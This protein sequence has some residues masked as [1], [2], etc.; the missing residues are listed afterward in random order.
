M[1]RMSREARRRQ[2]LEKNRTDRQ[3]AMQNPSGESKYA[4]KQEKKRTGKWVPPE[5]PLAPV[6][7]ALPSRFSRHSIWRTEED[8]PVFPR[9]R[10]PFS[11]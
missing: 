6:P 11:F 1:S 3:K 5:Q 10:S 7:K 8:E 2:G 4:E 9:P